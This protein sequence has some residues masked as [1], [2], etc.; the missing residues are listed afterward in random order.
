MKCADVVS[1]DERDE[2][3]DELRVTRRGRASDRQGQEANE[4]S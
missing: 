1:L 4:E 2:A 3:V